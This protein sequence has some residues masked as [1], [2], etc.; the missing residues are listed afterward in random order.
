MRSDGDDDDG[1]ASS[2]NVSNSYGLL[3]IKL[4]HLFPFSAMS[5]LKNYR[6][7][8]HV[9]SDVFRSFLLPYCP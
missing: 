9:E 5:S 4:L 2:S 3:Q 1:V 6:K 7:N 8:I